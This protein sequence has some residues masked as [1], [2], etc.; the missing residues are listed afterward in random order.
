MQNGSENSV[1][2]EI[3]DQKSAWKKEMREYIRPTYQ[4]LSIRDNDKSVILAR[5]GLD[6]LP[7]DIYLPAIKLGFDFNDGK[8]SS[9]EQFRFDKMRGTEESTQMYK[10][11]YCESIGV[12]LVNLWSTTSILAI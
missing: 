7:I 8:E 9:H 3:Q 2:Q 12:K 6:F 10:E 5:D 1:R 11:R 4:S